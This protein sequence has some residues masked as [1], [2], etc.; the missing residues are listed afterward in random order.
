MIKSSS[1]GTYR[2][3]G[4]V[5]ALRHSTSNVVRGF[6]NFAAPVVAATAPGAGAGVSRKRKQFVDAKK[7]RGPKKTAEEEAA[8]PRPDRS[9]HAD[10]NHWDEKDQETDDEAELLKKQ[11][12]TKKAKKLLRKKAERP[13]HLEYYKLI[14]DKDEYFNPYE[15]FYHMKH[16]FHMLLDGPTGSGKTQLLMD[17][18]RLLECFHSIYVLTLMPDEPLYKGLKDWFN[19][20]VMVTS[21]ITSLPK[22]SELREINP[23]NQT[24]MVFDDVLGMPMKMQE[25]IAAYFIAGRKSNCS[26]AV[27]TQSFF[28]IRKE[29]RLQIKYFFLLPGLEKN[30]LS[31]IA[32]HYGSEI[33]ELYQH[34]IDHRK[35]AEEKKEIPFLMIDITAPPE[36][37]YRSTLNQF[38]EHT[39]MSYD[40]SSS[41]DSDSDKNKDKDKDKDKT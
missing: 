12:G 41:D 21:D 35:E 6:S 15:R 38:L 32:L 18:I 25:V 39:G 20:F 30:D 23:K 33:V 22:P 34:M 37:R 8:E 3:P 9:K 24:L 14:T 16:P 2:L 36:R 27:I 29:I 40:S 5:L 1:G 31:F 13:L 19:G 4:K 10:S 26:C 11:P 17:V 28:R 7:S